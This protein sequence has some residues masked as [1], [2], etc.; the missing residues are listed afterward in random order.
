[1]RDPLSKRPL[2]SPHSVRKNQTAVTFAQE[3]KVA[4]LRAAAVSAVKIDH[5][6][7]AMSREIR[8]PSRQR[9]A[10]RKDLL[11]FC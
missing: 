5:P 4:T 6:T 10:I 8:A 11:T 7:T 1:M 3:R 2:A 9:Q